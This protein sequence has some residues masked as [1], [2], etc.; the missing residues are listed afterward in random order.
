M[1]II[2]GS[3]RGKQITAP[4]NLP[5]RPTTDFAK[6]ALFNILN[7]HFEFEDISV[8]DLFAG[9]GNISYEFASR[10][11]PD[12]LALDLHQQCVNFIQ[13]T[14]AKL[15]FFGLKVFR[16]DVIS[17]LEKYSQK[18]DVI[19]ADPPFDFQRIYELPALVFDN[20][21]LTPDGWLIIEH[22]VEISFSEHPCLFD[23]RKYGSVCF[24]FFRN[25]ALD[26]GE[27]VSDSR[28]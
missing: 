3:R 28:V 9:T 6:E 24:S 16:A 7:N 27:G 2:S 25:V 26:T 12:I 20:Q 5:V 22:S 11:V 13:Q 15:E 17:F 18:R 4:R 8:L 14:S 10:G 19:F 23:T 21:L 1:R